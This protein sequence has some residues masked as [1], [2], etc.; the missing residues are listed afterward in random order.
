MSGENG[1]SSIDFM[2][3]SRFRSPAS[4]GHETVQWVCSA[5]LLHDNIDSRV[6]ESR[7]TPLEGK[8]V[9]ASICVPS[10]RTRKRPVTRSPSASVKNGRDKRNLYIIGGR[11]REIPSIIASHPSS[12]TIVESGNHGSSLSRGHHQDKP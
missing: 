12:S 7:F 1:I 2:L 10:R 9:N 8:L 5:A 6:F 11:D 3:T 4:L